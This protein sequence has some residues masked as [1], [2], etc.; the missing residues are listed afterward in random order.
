MEKEIEKYI[1]DISVEKKYKGCFCFT[2]DVARLF[3]DG[4]EKITPTCIS[5]NIE[6]IQSLGYTIKGL[7]E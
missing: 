1:K 7:T 2:I 6:D 5:L 3:K 4:H